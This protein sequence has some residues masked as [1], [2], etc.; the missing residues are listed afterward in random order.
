MA[1][2]NKREKENIFSSLCRIGDQIQSAIMITNPSLPNHPIL[3]V[4]KMFT[5][6]TGYTREDILEKNIN[7]FKTEEEKKVVNGLLTKVKYDKFL[8]ADFISYKKDGTPFIND[9]YIQAIFDDEGNH[10]F[11]VTFFVDKNSK[12]EEEMIEEQKRI[13]KLAYTDPISSLTNYNYFIH[14][15]P[16]FVNVE[17]TGFLMLVQPTEYI[18]IVDSFGKALFGKIQFEIANRIQNSLSEIDHIVSRATEGSLIVVGLCEEQKIEHYVNKLLEITREPIVINEV[19]LYF[20]IRTGV[21][22][23][24]YYDGNL[25]DFVRLADIALSN[26]KKNVGNTIVFYKKFMSEQLQMKMRV[27]TELIYAIRNKEIYVHLQPKVN[28][29]SGKIQSFEALA[30][31][32]SPKLG[33]VAPDVF[34][35]AAEAIGKIKDIDLLVIEQVS[36]WIKTRM[37]KNLPLYQVSVNVS[38]GHFYL[39][40]FVYNLTN[41]VKHYGIDPYYI[42]VEL[43]E[44]I[45]LV[46]IDK[47]KEILH[48]LEKY[49]FEIAVDDFGKGFSSLNYIHQLPVKEIKIDRSFIQ[50]IDN[51]NA[52]SIVM[53]IV[54]LAYNMG[55]STVAEGIETVE[56]LSIIRKMSCNIAQGYYFYKPM[57]F[58]EIDKVLT[59][60]S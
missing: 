47:A 59:N 46:D 25:D 7:L 32:Y 26:T 17:D 60:E 21:V 28:I 58:D 11:N 23:L 37:E 6:I 38:P 54:Q 39:P 35:S 4:N 36:N 45:G 50:Q 3:Y 24:K 9:A 52:K 40:D 5:K 22:S 8:K 48:E 30:R 19:E 49:G 42:K 55:I 15:F 56:Q 33:Q 16:D 43:T 34:I 29:N 41:I 53:T 20:S 31:W 51:N 10:V 18:N 13:E 27:Q 12:N 1:N 14:R 44:S 57:P 2:E